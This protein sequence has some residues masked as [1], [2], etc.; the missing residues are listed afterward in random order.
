MSKNIDTTL[1]IL[2]KMNPTVTA[3]NDGVVFQFKEASSIMYKGFN[4]E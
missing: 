2:K 4:I 1:E 3:L